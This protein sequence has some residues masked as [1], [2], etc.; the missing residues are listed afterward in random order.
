VNVLLT[1]HQPLEALQESI[2]DSLG[3]LDDALKVVA[4]LD[5]VAKAQPG[6]SGQFLEKGGEEEA[7]F[8]ATAEKKKREE[9]SRRENVANAERAMGRAKL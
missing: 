4:E 5:L 7:R 3:G 1:P 8:A 6:I 2:V 9:A